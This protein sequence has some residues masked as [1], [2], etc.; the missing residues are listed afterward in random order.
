M[1]KMKRLGIFKA[2][3]TIV[4]I[5]ALIAALPSVSAKAADSGWAAGIVSTSWGSLNVRSLPDTGGTVLTKLPKGSYVTLLERSGE[6]WRVEYGPAK[7]GYVSAYYISSVAGAY[8]AG[9]TAY[10]LNVRAG[11]GTNN[12][13]KEVLKNGDTVIVLSAAGGWCRILYNGTQ[14][15]Y[16]SAKYLSSSSTAAEMKWPVPESK[17]INQYFSSGTHL[18][19]D[20]DSSVQGTAGDSVAAA[21]AGSVVYSG[22]LSGYGNVVYINSYFNGRYIQTRYA[23]LSSRRVSA[24]D[25]VYAGQEIGLMGST[26]TSSGVHLH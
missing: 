1:K 7:Y 6:W 12:S 23:H 5:I 19:I 25:S 24:G 26:G 15:G 18:G 3:V 8:A 20:I 10:Y 21:C 14:T 11:A 4:L 13:V 22:W 9:V 17:T 16:V 2:S